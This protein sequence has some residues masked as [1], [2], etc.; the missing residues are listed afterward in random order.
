MATPVVSGIA[1]LLKTKYPNLSSYDV[2][3]ILEETATDRGTSGYDIKYG[4][5]LVDPVKALSYDIKKLS[6][7]KKPTDSAILSGASLVNLSDKNEASYNGSITKPHQTYRYKIN[8]KT[9]DAIGLTLKMAKDYDNQLSLRYYEGTSTK[10]SKP[11]IIDDVLAGK[12]EGTVYEAKKDGTL[13]VEVMDK[14]ARYSLQGKS[15]FTLG[16][17]QNIENGNDFASKTN[18]LPISQMP[19]N[20]ESLTPNSLQLFNKGED[21]VRYLSFQP[22]EDQPTLM[23]LGAIPGLNTSVNVY[24]KDQWNQYVNTPNAK[25][26]FPIYS[27]DRNGKSEGEKGAFTFIKDNSYVIELSSAPISVFTWPLYDEK[28][29]SAVPYTGSL[30]KINFMM[31]KLSLPEDEDGLTFVSSFPDPIFLS[32][33]MGTVAANETNA[34]VDKALGL[35]QNVASTA[36]IQTDSDADWYK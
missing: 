34:V 31:S 35:T 14:N 20:S 7:Y 8:V 29:D 36:Y 23:S 3:Q 17:K 9:G 21:G 30:E 15:T 22:T 2:E 25:H 1:S 32:Q 11:I 4:Y 24:L 27:I 16:I 33:N 26:P 18:P 12:D 19:F 28:P 13:V 6:S 10:S 5:G